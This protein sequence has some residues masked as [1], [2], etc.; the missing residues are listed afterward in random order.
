MD[1]IIISIKLLHLISTNQGRS[2]KHFGANPIHSQK[3]DEKAKE[4][5]IHKIH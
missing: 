1:K 5:D 2:F 3:Q 4:K